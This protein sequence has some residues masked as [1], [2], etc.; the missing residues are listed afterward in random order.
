[1]KIWGLFHTK[2]VLSPWPAH[3][4]DQLKQLYQVADGWGGCPTLST[5]LSPMFLL[6]IP[7]WEKKKRGDE[8]ENIWSWEQNLVHDCVRQYLERCLKH[9]RFLGQSLVFPLSNRSQTINTKQNK[10]DVRLAFLFF[11]LSLI[12]HCRNSPVQRTEVQH[13]Q[14]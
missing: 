3:L 11:L 5:Y 14:Y 10:T 1:M 4:L 12:V 9:Q 8:E 2:Q 7:G 13:I 6:Q